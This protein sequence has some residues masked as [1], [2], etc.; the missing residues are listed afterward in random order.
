MPWGGE[1]HWFLV[2]GVSLL[3]YCEYVKYPAGCHWYLC[4]INICPLYKKSILL[5]IICIGYKCLQLFGDYNSQ[6]FPFTG[7]VA[8]N[9]TPHEKCFCALIL[10]FP[11]VSNVHIL[12]F[13]HA[14]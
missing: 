8:R 4:D 9:L 13:L 3:F 2:V 11:K 14:Y 7:L 10:L 5:I 1:S 12:F 6:P